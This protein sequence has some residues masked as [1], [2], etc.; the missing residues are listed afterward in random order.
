[1]PYF[2]HFAWLNGPAAKR[3]ALE[4]VRQRLLE[5]G[6]KYIDAAIEKAMSSAVGCDSESEVLNDTMPKNADEFDVFS[7]LEEAN[8]KKESPFS[9]V[10]LVEDIKTSATNALT[11]RVV[12]EMKSH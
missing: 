1:M 9:K 7:F 10:I 6:Q 12:D 11:T 5:L 3:Q 2:S 4:V 8:V